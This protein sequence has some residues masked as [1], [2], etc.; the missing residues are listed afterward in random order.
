MVPVPK[1][2]SDDKINLMTSEG[3]GATTD[4]GSAIHFQE[5]YPEQRTKLE[6]NEIYEMIGIGPAQYL[7]WTLVAL[8]SYSDFAELTLLSIIIPT[9]RCKWELTSE[10][11]AAIMISTFTS[12]ALCAL[13]FSRIADWY[14]RK[15]VI[16]WSTLLLLLATVGGA[17]SPNKWVFLATRLVT[18]AS[19]G[20]NWSCIICYGTEFTQSRFRTIGMMIFALSA[21]TG[22]V[23]VSG[24]AF[25]VLRADGW[26]WLIIIVSLPA[27]PALALIF[28]LPESP[29]FLCVSGQHDKAMKAVRFMARLNKKELPDNVQMISYEGE[30]LGSYSTLL[31]EDNK[32]STIALSV[33]FFNNIF[34]QYGFV[35]F[36]PLMLSTDFCGPSARQAHK[37]QLLSQEDLLKVTVA[38]ACS[39]VGSTAAFF[40]VHPFGRLLPLRV[41]SFIVLI[42]VGG[43]FICINNSVTLVMIGVFK[44][45][46]SFLTT[47]TVIMI[48]ESFSTNIRSTATGFINGWGKIGGVIG[49]G[50]VYVFFYDNPYIVVG[51]FLLNCFVLLITATIY[52]RE[53]QDEILKET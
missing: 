18:G 53:T 13:L 33:M 2:R 26:R 4:Y 14:G 8:V 24:V 39:L 40:S 27:I 16:K 48:P 35:A 23:A 5:L 49:T 7:N 17:V 32:K 3:D 9:L 19:I 6:L 28:T 36:L 11:E 31:N 51:L 50:C 25:V 41:A 22:I 29:R 43:L 38:G 52:D 10:F 21:A 12:Y 47:I 20:I 44:L 45:V 37:C 1:K 46:G 34:L 42:S 30:E 15:A